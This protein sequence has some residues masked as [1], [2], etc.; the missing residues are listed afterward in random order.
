[1]IVQNITSS[2]PAGSLEARSGVPKP[3]PEPH[4]RPVSEPSPQQVKQAAESINR[5]VKQSSSNLEFS[6]DAS[7]RKLVVRMV[8]TE[9]GELIRQVPSD[10]VLAI[11]ESI[12]QYQKGLLLTQQA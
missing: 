6:F 12:E 1:M 7:S 2:I 11:A 5:V 10:V 4:T 9:T 3:P 8:D